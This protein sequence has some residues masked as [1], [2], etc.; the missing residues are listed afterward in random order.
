G[1][2]VWQGRFSAWGETEHESSPRELRQNLRFQGQYFDA[3]TGLHYSLFRYYDPVGGRFT[4]T[5]PIGLAG[6][7][8]LYAYA[9]NPLSWI[10][11]LG[12][13]KC[14]FSGDRGR[15]KAA[16]DLQQNGYTVI[17]EELTMRVN[18]SRV[19]ADFVAVDGRGSI[20]VFEAKHGA[21]GLT[22]NQ[23]ASGVFD[24]NS[25]SNTAGGIGGG[26]ITSSSGTK[27]TFSVATSNTQKSGA[28]GPKGTSHDATFHVLHY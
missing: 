13:A 28:L 27:G 10:D 1:E 19:R 17:A 9:P 7:V 15:N 22:P 23:K 18:G 21:G 6:G 2:R 11:P 12:L 16:H 8:N 4:Q 14:H 5:D 3:E 25:P 26:T 24:M 20:H